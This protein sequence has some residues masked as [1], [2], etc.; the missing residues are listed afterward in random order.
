M[1]KQDMT[2]NGI[3]RSSKEKEILR[4]KLNFF[5]HDV[6]RIE[7]VDSAKSITEIFGTASRYI[8]IVLNLFTSMCVLFLLWKGGYEGLANIIDKLIIFFLLFNALYVIVFLF[9]RWRKNGK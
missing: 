3:D 2:R 7:R 1:V 5:N 8:F 6:T 4:K 9:N